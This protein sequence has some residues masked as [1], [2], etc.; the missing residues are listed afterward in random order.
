MI[1][2][3]Y[4]EY[5]NDYDRPKKEAKFGDLTEFENWFFDLCEGNWDEKISVPNPDNSIWRDGPSCL[6]VRVR[7][8]SYWIHLIMR[9]GAIIY[10]DGT[11]TSEIKYWNDLTKN[12]CRRMI[13]RKK[14]PRFNFG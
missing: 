3:K 4:E 9:D 10:S 5:S 7:G 13:E 14:N 8:V 11:H 1:K 6:E 12:M 2:I